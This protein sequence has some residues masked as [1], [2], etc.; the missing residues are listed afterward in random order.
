ML[1]LLLSFTRFENRESTGFLRVSN[2][3]VLDG[4]GDP[5]VLKGFNIAFKDFVGTLGEKDINRIADSGANS[6]RLVIDYR[7]LE[8]SPFEY[9]HKSFALLDTIV[10]WCE[11]YGIYLILDMHLAPG[12]QN[13]HD[14][15]VHREKS[16][17]FWEESQYQEQFYAL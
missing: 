12:I 1:F 3:V 7:Q 10:T 5:F 2:Q 11:K 13:P 17:R 6:I 14:F 8:L 16:Y 9:D 4:A 15:V